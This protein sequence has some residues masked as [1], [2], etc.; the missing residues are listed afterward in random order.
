MRVVRNRDW[1]YLFC[2]YF[3][4]IILQ[5]Q[6]VTARPGHGVEVGVAVAVLV[7]DGVAVAV[8]VA[9]RVGVGVAVGAWAL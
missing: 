4:I 8:A 2:R 7:G 6:Y 1:K 5:V 9:G 3:Q